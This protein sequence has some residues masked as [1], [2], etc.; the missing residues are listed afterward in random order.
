MREP[1]TLR[2]SGPNG[3]L[4]T[5]TSATIT[6]D[7]TQPAECA[8]EVGDD[9][10]ADI[11]PY[12]EMGATYTCYLNDRPRM[13]GRVELRDIPT[14]AESGACVRFTLI[15]LLSDAMYASALP[16]NLKNDT[17]KTFIVKLL[18][19]L[20]SNVLKD[21]IW[22]ADWAANRNLITGQ[23]G[24]RSAQLGT[25]LD[26]A[27]I[28]V[29]DAKVQPN[30]TI[31]DAADRHLR[32]HG[33][34]LWDGADGRLVI[35]MPDIYQE[36]LYYLRM[37]RGGEGGS[38]NMIAAT[39]TQDYTSAPSALAVHGQGGA[40]GYPRGRVSGIIGNDDVLA[41]GLYHP[42]TISAEGIRTKDMADRAAARE[43]ANRSRRSD[44]WEVEVDGLTYWD[45][46]KSI[47]WAM[48]TTVDIDSDVVDGPQGKYYCYRCSIRRDP[49][50][51]DLANLSLSRPETWAI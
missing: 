34:M 19:P 11:K 33:L 22:P 10:W 38:N 50:N 51:G 29:Q 25:A 45:G 14:D 26:L 31:W 32:R 39:R 2:L 36:P 23:R 7:L 37:K 44:L 43:M 35:G 13:K 18:S 48:D 15:S 5:F 3:D 16:I 17:L 41:A 4:L 12:I 6:N 47:P 30:E 28:T 9:V 40:K 21:I 27:K 1:D 24:K 49:Q 20:V 46:H 8:V 42:V